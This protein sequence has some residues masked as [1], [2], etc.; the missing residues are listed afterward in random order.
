M[1]GPFALSL[2]LYTNKNLAIPGS[3]KLRM[4]GIT[5]SMR[6]YAVINYE[7]ASYMSVNIIQSNFV[8]T[9]GSR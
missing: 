8:R 5:T 4:P 2:R 7:K 1:L 9:G 3:A 6:Y